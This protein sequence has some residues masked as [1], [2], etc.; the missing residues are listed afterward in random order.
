M[1]M[2]TIA[3]LILAVVPYASTIAAYNPDDAVAYAMTWDCDGCRNTDE[4]QVYDADCANFVSQCLIAGGLDLTACTDPDVWTDDRGCIISCTVLNEYLRWLGVN[5]ECRHV[6]E[7]EPEW[8][9]AIQSKS[10]ELLCLCESNEQLWVEH[11]ST[12]QIII[13]S[14][15][16]STQ[17]VWPDPV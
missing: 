17:T 4:Y 14:F 1:R 11:L 8:L 6:S 13:N 16:S 2:K 9:K 7:G 12:D 15:V 10:S 3:I 5:N